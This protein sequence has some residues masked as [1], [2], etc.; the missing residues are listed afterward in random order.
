MRF[1]GN[2]TIRR[3]ILTFE[4]KE[5]I[6]NGEKCDYIPLKMHFFFSSPCYSY[7]CKVNLSSLLTV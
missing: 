3:E 7:I 1:G 6:R 2:L 4:I 5:Y